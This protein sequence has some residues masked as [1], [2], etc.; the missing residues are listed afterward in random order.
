MDSLQPHQF[1]SFQELMNKVLG[2]A[3]Y[4]YAI[5]YLD[6]IFIYSSTFQEHLDHLGDVFEKLRKAGLKLKMSKCQFLMK[7]ISYLGH[8]ISEKGISPDPDKIKAISE[9]REPRN[10]REVRSFVGMASY[11][12]KFI[13]HFSDIVKPLTELTKKNS[14]FVWTD[15]HQ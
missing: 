10:V 2:Q 14:K 1:F 8:I 12:R 6:D 5:A 13:E 11:Y 9:L 4:K 7:Q 15:R 3:M